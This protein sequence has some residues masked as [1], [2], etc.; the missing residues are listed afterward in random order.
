MKPDD[1]IQRRSFLAASGAGVGALALLRDP[2]AALSASRR[3]IRRARVPL[4]RDGVFRHGVAS[5]QPARQ[6]ITLWTRVD[7]LER[8]S[9]LQVEVARD[10]DFRRLVHRQTVL[11]DAKRD[12]TVNVHVRSHSLRPGEQYFYRFTGCAQDSPVGRF[13]TARPSNSREPVR[14]GFFSCQ[15]Y[16]A[17]Y[18]TAHAGLAAEDDLDLV[19]CLGDYI[20]ERSFQDEPVRRDTLGANR[21]GEVQTLPEYR[22]KYNLYHTDR[23]LQAMRAAHP[24][25]AIWDDHEV[26]DNYADGLPGGQTEDRRIPYAQRQRNGYRAFFEHMPRIQNRTDPD[27]IY[28]R[29][30]L[31]GNAELLLLD[32]RR[33]RDDQP[34][35]P[36]DSGFEP[37]PPEERARPGR[38]MLGAAQKD[39][40]K[41]ALGASQATWKVVGNQVMMMALDVPARSPLNTDQWD[42]YEAERRELIDFIAARGI[43]DVSFITGDIHTF[44]AG[45]VTPSGR[46]GIPPIDGVPV[47][48]EFVGGSITSRGIADQAGEEAAAAIAPG[49]DAGA[50]ANNPHFRYSNQQYK[51]YGVLEARENEMLVEYRGVRTR[52]QR[53]SE[54]FTLQRFRVARGT[55]EVRL[56]GGA[57]PA[58]KPD[59]RGTERLRRLYESADH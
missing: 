52:E 48:T 20:Y 30:P 23:Q 16:E 38:T 53:E 50:L 19:V 14:I 47:A 33:F 2:D 55:P 57:V 59:S 17:G 54:V 51:G 6:G 11:A 32:Q 36:D 35:N 7:E 4:A 56:E 27:R 49:A 25:I 58:P 9:R 29:I 39:W 3:R 18:Y 24:M 26:E 31:G 28:G 45:Q 41:Q 34:C 43:N 5:G 21:D 13:K 22:A 12:F 10:A 44:F 15:D 37:C 42:G 8:T 40:F 46:Q 1:R